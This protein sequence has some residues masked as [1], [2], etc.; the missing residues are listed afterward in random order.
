MNSEH[1]YSPI[2][3][4]QTEKDRYIQRDTKLNITKRIVIVD[5]GARAEAAK[6]EP[7]NA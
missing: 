6:V 7:K 2:S 3:Q 1:V 4:T 5:L